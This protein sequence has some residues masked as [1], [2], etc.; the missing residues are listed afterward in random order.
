MFQST[1]PADATTQAALNLVEFFYSNWNKILLAIAILIIALV[2]INF[3]KIAL[4][5]IAR[6]YKLPPKLLRF[7]NTVVTYGTLIL[8]I[9]NILAVF[10]IHL[11]SLIVSLGLISA[12]IVL[13]SQL[14]ISNLLGGT[15]V[16]IE[17]PFE[18]DDVIKVGEN[19]GVVEGISFRST[20]MRGLNGLVITIPNSTYLT[21]P[22]TNYTRT[23]QYLVKLPFTMPR[24]V[25]MSGLIDR[26]RSEASSIPG[27][28]SGKGETLYKMGISK[29][30]VDYELHFW[31]SDPRV[32]DGARSRI[33][34]IIGQFL[35]TSDKAG[36]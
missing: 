33:V 2:V 22:I 7:L 36:I 17:K 24:N 31:I 16:Y 13:G 1:S 32:S 29:D 34:D 6:D 3:L 25:D 18:I 10:D 20:T 4:A 14:V 27:F 5:Q 12:V 9:V 35:P 11:Y 8:A 30:N 19:T 23:R 28:S 15:I 26:L 21:T